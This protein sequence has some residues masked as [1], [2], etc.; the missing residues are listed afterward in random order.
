MVSK[1]DLFYK[2]CCPIGDCVSVGQEDFEK[3]LNEY[4]EQQT[5]SF[6]SWYRSPEGHKIAHEMATSGH[7]AYQLFLENQQS[8]EQ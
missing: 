2:Y 8:K 5:L 6:W 3:A 1:D 4:A 7:H